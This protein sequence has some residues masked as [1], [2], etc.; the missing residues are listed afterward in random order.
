MHSCPKYFSK[1][2]KVVNIVFIPNNFCC[3]ELN[4]YMSYF[5]F[6][7]RS[8]VYYKLVPLCGINFYNKKYFGQ[9]CCPYYLGLILFTGT[10]SI[11]MKGNRLIFIITISLWILIIHLFKRILQLFI[12]FRT[13]ESI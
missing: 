5:I 11:L 9:M 13:R 1:V 6:W 10:F 4:P 7:K 3:F 12:E 8:H 2:M